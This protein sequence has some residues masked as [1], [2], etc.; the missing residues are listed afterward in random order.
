MIAVD[1]DYNEVSD[2]VLW[3]IENIV[4]LNDEQV[5]GNDEQSY[6]SITYMY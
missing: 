6:Y 1:G 4:K 5:K 2:A 3:F